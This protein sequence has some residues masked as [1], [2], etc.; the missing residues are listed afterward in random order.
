MTSLESNLETECKHLIVN[1]ALSCRSHHLVR[2]LGRLAVEVITYIAL[3]LCVCI[4]VVVVVLP[5]ENDLYV[6]V[7]IIVETDCVS[8][9]ATTE[10][11][12]I[13][14]LMREKLAGVEVSILITESDFEVA[15]LVL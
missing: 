11:I 6:L 1:A 13:C 2:I 4:T 10:D 7:R 3:A 12:R 14:H 15:P 8:L 9:A 5:V